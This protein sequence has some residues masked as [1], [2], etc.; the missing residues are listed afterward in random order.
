MAPVRRALLACLVFVCLAPPALADD[1]SLHEARTLSPERCLEVPVAEMATRCPTVAGRFLTV[2]GKAMAVL[3]RLDQKKGTL[4]CDQDG[5]GWRCRRV[6]VLDRDLR[7]TR[8]RTPQAFV[9]TA[10]LLRM[11]AQAPTVKV[12]DEI[13]A[14]FAPGDRPKTCLDTPAHGCA[15]QSARLRGRAL[16][17]TGTPVVRRRLWL[18]EDADGPMLACSDKEL[19]RC[20]DLTAA[21]W[22]ALIVTL[23]PSSMAPA[24][25]L[26]EI[27][28]PEVRGD[29]RP[30]L[31]VGGAE[32]ADT[33]AGALDPWF[34]PKAAHALPHEP[35]RTDVA[36]IAHA[37]E[38]RGRPCLKGEPRAAI[39]VLFS[40]EGNLIA[41]TVDGATADAPVASCLS[42]IAKK[43]DF[44]RFAGNT[45]HLKAVVLAK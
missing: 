36:K 38:Q 11:L 20:D 16:D 1:V 30:A 18:V 14:L 23:R 24:V 29:K 9:T 6:V 17:R 32:A 10:E 19:T 12:D 8:K 45:Y 15:V 39:D 28:V 43:L 13:G 21:G 31:A 4:W 42:T 7:S 22:L 3:D 2:D 5:A 26:P 34:K 35:A 44:P 33:P 40:G 41:L 37:L 27:D 25:P